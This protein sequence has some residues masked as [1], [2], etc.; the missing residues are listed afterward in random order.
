MLHR[1]LPITNAGIA[2]ISLL[3]T[4][5]YKGMCALTRL[6]EVKEQS[7]YLVNR[8]IPKLKGIIDPPRANESFT[9]TVNVVSGHKEQSPFLR[10][11]SIKGIE[12]A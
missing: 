8:S 7:F 2:P 12:Q 1:P 6:I 4:F 3:N 5:I 10:T 9:K 11:H